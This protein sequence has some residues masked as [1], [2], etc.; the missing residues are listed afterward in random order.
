ML[1]P[2]YSLMSSHKAILFDFDGVIG[3]TMEDNFAAWQAA[4]A[5]YGYVLKSDDYFPYEGEKLQDMAARFCR[6]GGMQESL[7]EEIVRRKDEYYLAH[8]VFALYP[9]V[10]ELLA[11]LGE[12]KIPAGLVTAARRERLE[13]SVPNE[14]LKILRR[15]SR[16][17]TADAESRFLIPIFSA[18]K[19]WVFR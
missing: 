3:K 16:T 13:K 5:P 15:L 1:L 17:K 9:G 14:F 10:P 18:R 11:L 8:H 2:C 6:D 12:N 7:A 4:L 19:G